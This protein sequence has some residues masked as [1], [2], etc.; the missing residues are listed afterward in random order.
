MKIKIM[1]KL[2]FILV[3]VLTVFA[4]CKEEETVTINGLEIA[5]NPTESVDVTFAI[6]ENANKS[7][8]LNVDLNEIASR[9]IPIM[10]KINSNSSAEEGTH[11][12]SPTELTIPKGQ[13][14]INFLQFQAMKP[15]R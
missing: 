10:V 4:A 11:F 7:I 2:L 8:S 13:K 14:T 15:K 1:K 3:A 5:F 9:D 6:D 12:N